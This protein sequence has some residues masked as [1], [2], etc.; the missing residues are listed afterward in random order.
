MKED[1]IGRR[2][3]AAQAA[4]ALLAG[5]ISYDQFLQAIPDEADK[6]IGQLVDLIEHEPKRGGWG[7]VDENAWQSYRRQI[8]AA[9]EALEFGTQG[10]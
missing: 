10:H 2:K 1:C 3:A 5:E 6:L 4:R 9:I 7:G 8:L